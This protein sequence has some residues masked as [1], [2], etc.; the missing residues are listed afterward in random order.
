MSRTQSDK[1]T[2][3]ARHHPHSKSKTDQQKK[4]INSQIKDNKP[5]ATGNFERV[6]LTNTPRIAINSESATTYCWIFI[7]FYYK[8]P[9]LTCPVTDSVF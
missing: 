3:S 1:L 2:N 5:D 6:N 7:H 9:V 4:N 8:V